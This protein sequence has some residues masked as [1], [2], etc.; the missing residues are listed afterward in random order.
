M[1]Q[2][3]SKRVKKSKLPKGADDANDAALWQAV[4]GGG[5]G[6]G[7]GVSCLFQQAY[8][9]S[10]ADTIASTCAIS[11]ATKNSRLVSHC[12]EA[13]STTTG[14]AI[15]TSAIPCHQRSFPVAWH[16]SHRS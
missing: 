1:L 15:S 7:E 16:P 13:G 2:G 8:T 9:S 10:G 11:A 5:N 12:R 14:M 4:M 3:K 6:R